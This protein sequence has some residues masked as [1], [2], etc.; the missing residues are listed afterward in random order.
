MGQEANCEARFG[1]KVSAGRALLETDDLIFRGE[2]RLKIPLKS[3]ESLDVNG[4]VLSVTSPA[5]TADFTLGAQAG[6][7]AHK[8]RNPRSLADKLDVKPGIRVSLI[9]VENPLEGRTRDVTEG[10]AAKGSDLIFFGAE[11][12]KD[13]AKLRVLQKALKPRGAIWVVYPKGQKQ[14]TEVG[15]IQA[16][17]QAG[18]VDIKVARFSETHTALKFTFP[19]HPTP[20]YTAPPRGPAYKPRVGAPKP[21]A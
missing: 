5:G 12:D 18:M 4:G 20:S 14:I 3:I 13:L 17:R 21:V 9:G 15:V 19:A 16:G 7:W 2:F 10:T 8:I 1:G 11:K 6:K